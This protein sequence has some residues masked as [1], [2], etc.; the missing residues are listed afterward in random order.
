MKRMLFSAI[1]ASLL[2][3][4]VAYAGSN[5]PEP[6]SKAEESPGLVCMPPKAPAPQQEQVAPMCF[7]GPCS[8]CDANYDTCIAGCNG[9]ATCE[10]NCNTRYDFCY[11]CCY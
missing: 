4:G 7:I 11:R 6:V 1:A 9:D 3:V 10:T 8:T 5:T 2:F